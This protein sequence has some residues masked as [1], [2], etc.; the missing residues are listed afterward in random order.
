MYRDATTIRLHAL[1]HSA[2]KLVAFEHFVFIALRTHNLQLTRHHVSPLSP[3]CIRDEILSIKTILMR[4]RVSITII[5]TCR[6]SSSWYSFL[7][8]SAAGSDVSLV[9]APLT[10][11]KA[12]PAA[13]ALAPGPADAAAAASRGDT[14]WPVPRAAAGWMERIEN[15]LL[16]YIGSLQCSKRKRKRR[17]L[18]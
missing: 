3:T 16:L 6:L 2:T 9:M 1:Y 10:L 14:P 4:I 5:T 8:A 7:L 13:T 12:G 11:P 18:R 17:R 15:K